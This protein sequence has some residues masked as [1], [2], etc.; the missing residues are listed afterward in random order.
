[1]HG[2]GARVSSGR[3]AKEVPRIGLD[4]DV[5]HLTPRDEGSLPIAR[6][7]DPR[8]IPRRVPRVLPGRGPRGWPGRV[9]RG[10]PATVGQVST[11]DG[12]DRGS[13]GLRE[14]GGQ[15]GRARLDTVVRRLTFANDL[16]RGSRIRMVKRLV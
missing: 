1:M 7:G 8:G 9:T 5:G 3:E 14:S 6:D 4:R 11:H 13:I 10:V 12:G 2:T 16:G 15:L